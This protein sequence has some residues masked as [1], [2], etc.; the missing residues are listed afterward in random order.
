MSAGIVRR[1]SW[2]VLLLGILPGIMS[3]QQQPT[4]LGNTKLEKAVSE[5]RGLSGYE[6]WLA[7]D[8]KWII[9]DAERSAFN[10]LR[11]EESRQ[12]FVEQFWSQRDPT[13]DTVRNEFEELHYQ[14]LLSA[15]QMFST[16]DVMGWDTA[17]G[18][19]YVIYGPPDGVETKRGAPPLGPESVVLGAA[20]NDL[21]RIQVSAY[22]VWHYSKIRGI[23]HPATI[24]FAPLC[25]PSELL[26]VADKVD[27]DTLGRPPVPK[28]KLICNGKV[29]PNDR[30]YRGIQQIICGENP[31]HVQFKNLEEVVTAHVRYSLF[32]FGVHVEFAKI[33]DITDMLQLT[34]TVKNSDVTCRNNKTDLEAPVRIFGRFVTVNGRVAQIVEGTMGE[35]VSNCLNGNR[36]YTQRFPLRLGRYRF[37]LAL[38]DVNGDRMGTYAENIV[39]PE[40][41]P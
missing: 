16:P 33:T 40:L 41:H 34:I 19:I 23:D 7:Q 32:T 12:V 8:V 29:D 5:D 39:V 24:A 20:C 17:R 26:A 30:S 38:Q 31:P 14:R 1:F 35:P 22:E 11:D 15:R 10:S 36:K 21:S 4:P 25:T 6:I 28:Y 2:L 27:A 3:A 18:R 37:N 9:T 13:P